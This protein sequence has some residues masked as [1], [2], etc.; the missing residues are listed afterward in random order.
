MQI[1]PTT[2]LQLSP[3]DLGES[4]RELGAKLDNL[5]RSYETKTIHTNPVQAAIIKAGA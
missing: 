2:N 1:D 3:I 5:V 4:N